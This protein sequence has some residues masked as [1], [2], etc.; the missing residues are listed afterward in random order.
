MKTKN[1]FL[2]CLLG[3]T[4]MMLSCQK[5]AGLTPELT[6]EQSMDV[7]QNSNPVFE[8]SLEDPSPYLDILSNYPDPFFT[9]TKI[10]FVIAKTS[11]VSLS[12]VN[13]ETGVGERLFKGTVYKGVYYKI[14]DG[15]NK[16]SGKYMATLIVDGR[17]YKE[18]MTK[19]SKWDP[20]P[21]HDTEY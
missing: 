18:I 14:F 11:E 12:V 5:D 17:S 10:K 2:V 1:L 9:F 4:L 16:S 21:V 20:A 3:A 7:N 6:V 19:R 13:M 8:S 15:T